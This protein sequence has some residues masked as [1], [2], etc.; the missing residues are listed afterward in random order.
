MGHNLFHSVRVFA[1]PTT[2]RFRKGEPAM[3]LAEVFDLCQEIE[4]RHAKLYATLS[5]LLGNIDERIARF[6]E[7][8]SAEEW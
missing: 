1:S 7:Q 3:T 5:L 8:M 4:L 2:V 6:W